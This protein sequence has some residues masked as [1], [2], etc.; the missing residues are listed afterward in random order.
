MGLEKFTGPLADP[1][2]WL[3]RAS[4]QTHWQQP[5]INADRFFAHCVDVLLGLGVPV[6]G[7]CD[8]VANV[9]S[10]VGWGLSIA[11]WNLGGVKATQ[12]WAL[13]YKSRTGRDAPWWRTHGNVGTGDSQT[14]FY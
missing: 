7:A 2:P 10:E 12:G 11:F 5:D 6:L 3:S 14:V 1:P 13:R 8:I 9:I 4:E